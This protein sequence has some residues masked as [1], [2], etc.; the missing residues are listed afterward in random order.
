MGYLVA[1]AHRLKTYD[2]R[3][4]DVGFTD[5][6]EAMGRDLFGASL[7]LVGF[8]LIGRRVAELVDAFEM[9]VRVYDPYVDNGSI[10]AGAERVG[11]DDLLG[12]SEFV[13]LHCPLTDETA[14]LLDADAFRRMRTDAILVNTARGGIYTDVDLARALRE[15]QIAGAAI[16]VF[17][18]EP[19]VE[20]SPLLSIEECLLTPHVAGVTADSFERIGR[21]L[22]DAVER[23]LDGGV[24]PN[25]LNP[26]TVD[27]EVPP[28]KHSPSFIPSREL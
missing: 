21:I 7:G 23:V 28:E 3:I 5:R 20:D 10:P 13:S 1:G 17:E 25:I 2:T 8:G 12:T 26:S 27:G 11:L 15:G 9:D 18:T 19:A 6:H 24:P 4:R 22:Y 16:D 14:G